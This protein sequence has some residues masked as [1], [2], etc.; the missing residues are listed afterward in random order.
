MYLEVYPDVI[1][2]LNFILDFI[3]LTIL[4]IINRKDSPAIRRILAAIIGGSA[5]AIAGIF[6]WMNVIVRFIFLNIGTAV[7]MLVTAFGRMK[8]A[9]LVKQLISL[10]LITYSAGGLINAIYYQTDAGIS[11]IR[12]GSTVMSNS[13]IKLILI[14]AILF[15]PSVVMI[16]RMLRRNKSRAQQILEVELIHEGKC[17]ITKGL[18]DTGNKLYDPVFHKPVIIMEPDLLS[19]LLTPELMKEFELMR[20]L[21]KGN[22]TGDKLPQ[23]SGQKGLSLRIIPFCS[24]GSRDGMMLGFVLDKILLHR[25][26]ETICNEKVTAAVCDDSLTQK[27]DYHVILHE[28]LLP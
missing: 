13:S 2:I 21:L 8:T 24:V 11:L 5:A 18:I 12:F 19:E 16:L 9:E 17:L 20:A 22:T 3:L 4:K 15:V 14:P 27:E 26:T 7:L 23:P 6:P 25:G 28:E 10:C 1:F